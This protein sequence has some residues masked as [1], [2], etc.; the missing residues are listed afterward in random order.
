MNLEVLETFV[1][2]AETENFHQTAER[3][4]LSQP[5]VTQ[6]IRRLEAE[7]G[8]PLFARSGTSVRLSPGGR[9]FLPYARKILNE[10]RAARD[11]ARVAATT[12]RLTLRIAASPYISRF[13]LPDLLSW[14]LRGRKGLDWSLDVLP[15]TEIPA[16]VAGGGADLGL[17][18][19]EPRLAGVRGELLRDDPFVLVGAP[20]KLDSGL[21]ASQI[22]QNQTLLTHGA[23]GTWVEV[24]GA[25]ENAGV[26]PG[27]VLSAG[28]V[29][30]ARNFALEGLGISFLPR[31]SVA[32]ALEAG[33]LK[34]IP[35]S[36]MSLPKDAVYS[37]LPMTARQEA[38]DLVDFAKKRTVG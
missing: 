12:G 23:A 17:S 22:I 1:D 6:Q 33:G 14:F 4:D 26:K 2:A 27:R 21:E 24:L 28:Q 18:R 37:V 25:L 20:D 30:V 3:R 7:I 8:A 10:A 11:E 38:E 16:V 19:A 31:S 32:S 5:A 29:D 15:S 36:L 9:L 35:T 34:E 13:Y